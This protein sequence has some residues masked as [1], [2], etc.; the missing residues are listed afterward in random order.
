MLGRFQTDLGQVSEE[1]RQLQSQSQTMSVKLRNR[2]A[3]EERLG[4]FVDRIA[5]PND[6]ITSV[7]ESEVHSLTDS[8]SHLGFLGE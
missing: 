6:M 4:N 8:P 1:I 2:R 3:A 7:L 5:V